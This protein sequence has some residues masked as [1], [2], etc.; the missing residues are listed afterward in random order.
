MGARRTLRSALPR[1]RS[2]SHTV[3]VGSSMSSTVISTLP[4]PSV[5][6]QPP[7]SAPS[8]TTFPANDQRSGMSLPAGAGQPLKSWQ[9][10][11]SYTD[12]SRT[13]PDGAGSG[14]PPSV[15]KVWPASSWRV[16]PASATAARAAVLVRLPH[17]ATSSARH[18]PCPRTYARARWMRAS[19]SPQAF[20][21]GSSRY[22]AC[23]SRIGPLATRRSSSACIMSWPRCQVSSGAPSV[24]AS[25]VPICLRVSGPF[26]SASAITAWRRGSREWSNPRGR[27]A[28]SIARRTLGAVAVMR[29]ARSS[30]T[31]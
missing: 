22:V 28:E 17:Q 18:G 23:L 11:S 21:S 1:P 27:S 31:T 13:V 29:G 2:P 9:K 7:A 8:T 25:T 4:A 19:S 16:S 26:A 6:D 15:Q 24:W 14:R 20:C 30:G 12:S 3:R 5:L 10:S